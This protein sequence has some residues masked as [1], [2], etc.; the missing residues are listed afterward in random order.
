MQYGFTLNSKTKPVLVS[1]VDPKNIEINL[2]GANYSL[3]TAIQ[4]I[5]AHYEKNNPKKEGFKEIINK[6]LYYLKVT[7]L[8]ILKS[9]PTNIMV[10]CYVNSN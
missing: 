9:Y 10:L 2:N 7:L 5:K 4:H 3:L 1:F 8:K 6:S